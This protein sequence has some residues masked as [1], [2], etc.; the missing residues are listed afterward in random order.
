M[1]T[2]IQSLARNRAAVST[3]WGGSPEQQ[4]EYKEAREAL[5]AAARERWHDPEFHR[6][7][8]ADI[9]SIVDYGFMYETLFPTY[10]D[11]E[12]VGEFDRP[13]IRER[14]GL[15][16]FYTSRGGYIEES[17]LRSEIWELP[18]D[19]MGF[20]ISEHIDK[21]RANFA[22]TIEDLINLG[23][24]RL[25]AEVHRRSLSL[26]QAA[27]PVGASNYTN[28]TTGITAAMV[29]SAL[30]SVK[31]AIRPDGSGMPV[32][33][34]L[35]RAPVTDKLT[36]FD[37]GF[38]PEVQQ[39]IMNQGRLGT[40]RGAQVI[41]LHHYVDEENVAYVPANELW[42]FSG[43]VGK[44]VVYGD[45]Q[46]KQWDED[47]VDYRHYRARKDFGGLV[48]HPERAWRLVDGTIPA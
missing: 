5:N 33:T 6:E 32:L 28:A 8:A 26:M 22:D 40:Y 4:R 25:T 23:T 35:G 2:A 37:F 27:V 21:L 48:H 17:Q 44:F 3:P 9:Q 11:I 29:T 41:T 13:I 39:E 10:F 38:N 16:V 1:T 34:I 24:N 46:T 47:T 43:N 19:T 12:Q 45:L 20:H 42:I 30:S 31:D 18:R 7:V 36:T 14:R 15:K